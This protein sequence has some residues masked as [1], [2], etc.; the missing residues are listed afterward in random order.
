[1]L[2]PVIQD[3]MSRRDH[4]LLNHFQYPKFVRVWIEMDTEDYVNAGTRVQ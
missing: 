4:P 3:I 1:M 2:L